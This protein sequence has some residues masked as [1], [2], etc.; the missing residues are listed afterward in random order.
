PSCESGLG[1]LL[2]RH[3][4]VFLLLGERW[5]AL[6]WVLFLRRY[7]PDCGVVGEVVC[8]L[9]GKLGLQGVAKR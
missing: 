2:R 5:V 7:L 9:R 3:V 6:C 1:G 8:R 4:L